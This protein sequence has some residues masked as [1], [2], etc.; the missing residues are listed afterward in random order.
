MLALVLAM[1]ATAALIL[2]QTGAANAIANGQPVQEGQYG[3]TVKL[4]MTGIP[5][6]GGGKRNSG[7]S[8]ALISRQWIIT[9][10]HCFRDEDRQRVERPVADSTV[11]TFGRADVNSPGGHDLEI[12]AVR[13]SPTTDVALAK[14]ATPVS[15][16]RPLR[17]SQ[18]APALGDIVRL[19]GFGSL[20]S[21][22][23]VPETHAQT[24]QFTVESL[25]DTTTGV[26]G[27]APAE[28]TSPCPY[29]SGAPYFTEPAYGQPA[30]VAVESSGP[31][32]PHNQIENAARTDNIA[33][34]IREI[35]YYG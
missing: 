35:A 22:N 10:G 11:A 4:T 33:S 15:D 6:K 29:D 26:K 20:T 34:W 32:C 30:L 19:T 21:E 18:K 17:I 13:Q 1:P 2:G 31:D 24:G 23:P 14:L 28:N 3:F 12:V 8:G 7:C 25:T 16:V 5:V 27:H 9:A